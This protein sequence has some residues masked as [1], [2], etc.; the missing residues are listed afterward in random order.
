MLAF[1]LNC[2]NDLT[3]KRQSEKHNAERDGINPMDIIGRDVFS[4]R[5]PNRNSWV[6]IIR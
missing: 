5:K 6:L 4:A 2:Q 3:G 1:S